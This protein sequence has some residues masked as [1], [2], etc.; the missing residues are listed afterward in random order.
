LRLVF[1]V[2]NWYETLLNHSIHRISANLH[3]TVIISWTRVTSNSSESLLVVTK[4]PIC[5]TDFFLLS[6]LSSMQRNVSHRRRLF[7]TKMTTYKNTRDKL[8]NSLYYCVVLLLF[9]FI[10]LLSIWAVQ[11]QMT[12]IEIIDPLVGE[13]DPDNTKVSQQRQM[14]STHLEQKNSFLMTKTFHRFMQQPQN[15]LLLMQR[16][17]IKYASYY[18]SFTLST[19]LEFY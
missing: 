11:L 16:L 9:V 4:R 5:Y 7:P 2:E 17:R 12:P 6:R 19:T 8:T 1:V 3:K 10:Q 15:K 13:D 18:K 14:P